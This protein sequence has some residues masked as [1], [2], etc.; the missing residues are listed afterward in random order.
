[1][2]SVMTLRA[3]CVV[4]SGGRLLIAAGRC[5]RIMRLFATPVKGVTRARRI[6]VKHRHA[7]R[8]RRGDA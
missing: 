3:R 6:A 4:A 2:D 7:A 1:M 8:T 5:A